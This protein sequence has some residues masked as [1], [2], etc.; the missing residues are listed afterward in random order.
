MNPWL[1]PWMQFNKLPLSGS[2]NQDIS[3]L[4]GWLSPQFEFNFAGDR[5]VESKVIA[6]VASYGKQLGVIS[7]AIL[8]LAEG[9][10]GEAIQKLQELV[11]QIEAVKKQH[12]DQLGSRVRADLETLKL[13]DP[14]LLKDLLKQYR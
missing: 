11:D 1:S 9:K 13:K 7:E 12:A 10:N 6:D 8:E 4:S 5:H 14:E 2:V 3:P